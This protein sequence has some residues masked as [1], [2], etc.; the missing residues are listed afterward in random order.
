M[1]VRMLQGAYAGQTLD[2]PKAEAEINISTGF[3]EEVGVASQPADPADRDEAILSA[4]LSMS[5]QDPDREDRNLWTAQ[6]RPSLR[7]LNERLAP[8][9]VEVKSADERDRLWGWEAD[10]IE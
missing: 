5:M 3:A 7:E 4:M 6:N 10:K 1:R 2:M 9:G 8:H